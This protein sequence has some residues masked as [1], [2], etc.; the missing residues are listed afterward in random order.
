MFSHEQRT[1]AIYCDIIYQ[2]DKKEIYF[3]KIK[4]F[5]LEIK[6]GTVTVKQLWLRYPLTIAGVKREAVVVEQYGKLRCL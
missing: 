5:M 1:K 3:L 2:I 4:R 6:F